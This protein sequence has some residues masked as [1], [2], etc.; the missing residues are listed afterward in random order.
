MR[1]RRRLFLCSPLYVC[2]GLIAGACENDSSDGESQPSPEVYDFRAEDIGTGKCYPEAVYF[3]T[4][5]YCRFP[6]TLPANK[7]AFP[8]RAIHA[9]V[10]N[11]RPS[12][13][14]SSVNL[15]TRSF[16][17]SI[18]GDKF[19]CVGLK[20]YLAEEQAVTLTIGDQELGERARSPRK[21]RLREGEWEMRV[22]FPDAPTRTLPALPLGL[23]HRVQL[24]LPALSPIGA[25]ST[26]VWPDGK[27]PDTEPPQATLPLI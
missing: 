6:L 13:S 9:H 1:L 22:D 26:Q 16:D 10:A 18:E 3:D 27:N 17:C 20:Q 19:L 12:D 21:R 7:A 8:A 25:A 14:E 24:T 2:V 4:P 15:A 11:A 23:P 5:F